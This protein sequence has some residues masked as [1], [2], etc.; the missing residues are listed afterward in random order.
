MKIIEHV[1]HATKE[2]DRGGG[3]DCTPAR[4]TRRHSC[5]L[6]DMPFTWT[7]GLQHK[8][9]LLAL[10]I[11]SMPTTALLVLCTK[12]APESSTTEHS[13]SMLVGNENSFDS[14]IRVFW[15]IKAK[16]MPIM[17]EPS[18]IPDFLNFCSSVFSAFIFRRYSDEGLRWIKL[19]LISRVRYQ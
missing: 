9:C 5:V 4:P 17:F 7:H 11:M 2:G 13:V 15:K 3:G 6:K 18:P 16:M 8:R 19:L 10:C 1:K 14:T 12:G